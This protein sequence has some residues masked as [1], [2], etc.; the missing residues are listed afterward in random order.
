MF[1]PAFQCIQRASL[2]SSALVSNLRDRKRKTKLELSTPVILAG[3]RSRCPFQNGASSFNRLYQRTLLVAQRVQIDRFRPKD[4]AFARD[5]PDT[6]V[7]SACL[8]AI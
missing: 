6:Q 2:W 3:S 4:R 5:N 8:G 1:M 7:S